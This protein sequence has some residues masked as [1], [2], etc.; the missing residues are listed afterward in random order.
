[1][2]WYNLIWTAESAEHEMKRKTIL[3]VLLLLLVFLSAC[4]NSPT[5]ANIPGLAQTLAVRT[6]V[7][8][9][10]IEYF[11]TCTPSP[12]PT[13]IPVLFDEVDYNTSNILN[14]E[15][16]TPSPIPSLTPIGA[17]PNGISVEGCR[18][19]A[20]FVQDITYLDLTSVKAGERF[21]KVWRIRNSGTCTWTPKYSIVFTYG[22]RMNGISPKPLGATV[23]P[24]ETIDISVDLIAP[25]NPDIYQ[26]NWMLQD[27]TGDLFGTGSGPNNYFWVAIVVGGKGGFGGFS[28]IFGGCGGGG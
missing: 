3:T 10:G 15:I 13:S 9:R 25:K 11:A 21:T 4:T 8:E 17:N 28:P 22:D 2:V 1:M 26:G 27:E 23:L 18:N 7:A 14:S 16:P 24:G 5:P 19:K 6:M 20:E 12:V